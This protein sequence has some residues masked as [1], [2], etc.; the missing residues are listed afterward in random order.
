MAADLDIS[1]YSLLLC[2]NRSYQAGATAAT[3]PLSLVV[4][5]STSTAT[6]RALPGILSATLPLASRRPAGH[7]SLSVRGCAAHALS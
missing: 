4:R 6:P 5:S 3:S 2:S 7:G 1:K